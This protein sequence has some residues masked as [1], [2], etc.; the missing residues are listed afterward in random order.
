MKFFLSV[1]WLF[2]RVLKSIKWQ[3]TE[4]LLSDFLLARWRKHF[5]CCKWL[6]LTLQIN[7]SVWLW[8]SNLLSQI[9]EAVNSTTFMTCRGNFYW[10]NVIFIL[11][12]SS[13]SSTT[14]EARVK[15][16]DLLES[17][18]TFGCCSHLKWVTLVQG[19]TDIFKRLPP[20]W[21]RK[22]PRCFSA[23][24]PHRGVSRAEALSG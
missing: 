10:K 18:P 24:S 8:K 6:S 11:F 15:C 5:C 22:H 21:R 9:W 19:F 14:A 23:C 17:F 16:A 7:P 20:E 13:W 3:N 1:H 4:F 2:C 12:I